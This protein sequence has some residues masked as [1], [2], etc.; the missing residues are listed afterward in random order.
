[1]EDDC[2]TE[3][4]KGNGNSSMTNGLTWVGARETCVSKNLYGL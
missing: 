3:M 1:M 4:F 2:C